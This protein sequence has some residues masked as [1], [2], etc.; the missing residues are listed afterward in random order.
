MTTPQRQ[1]AL[2]EQIEAQLAAQPPSPY[3]REERLELALEVQRSIGRTLPSSV[4]MIR[5][6]RAR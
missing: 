5:R 6:D 1:Q 3:T 4:P 2:K